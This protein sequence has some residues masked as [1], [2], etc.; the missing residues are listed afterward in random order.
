MFRDDVLKSTPYSET[1]LEG[2]EMKVFSRDQRNMDIH[3][4]YFKLDTTE[5]YQNIRLSQFFRGG[6]LF[7]TWNL[8]TV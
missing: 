2:Y 1:M 4:F 5:E 8:F 7:T 6:K 3:T